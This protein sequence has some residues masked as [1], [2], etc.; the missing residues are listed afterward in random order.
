MADTK[1][2]SRTRHVVARVLA[3]GALLAFY[4]V[5]TVAIS[6]TMLAAT[7]NTAAAQWRGGRGYRGGYR[8]RGWRGGWRGYRGRRWVCRHAYWNSGR[9]CFWAF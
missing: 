6:G 5:G 1:L 9:R 4:G 2:T 7:T 8:G 3:A